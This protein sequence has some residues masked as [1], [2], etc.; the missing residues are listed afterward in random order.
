MKLL[1][2]E[3]KPLPKYAMTELNDGQLK[4]KVKSIELLLVLNKSQHGYQWAIKDIMYQE[5]LKDQKYR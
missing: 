3:S 5:T 2:L 4:L 1:L